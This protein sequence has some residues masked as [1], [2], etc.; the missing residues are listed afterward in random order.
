RLH[1]AG[2]PAARGSVAALGSAGY[3]NQTV[4]FDGG[5]AL[6]N[7]RVDRFALAAN[8]N[9]HLN[10]TRLDVQAGQATVNGAY[11]TAD[12]EIGGIG[13]TSLRYDVGLHV[14]DAPLAPFARQVLPQRR[15]IAGTLSADLRVSG[16][17]Q[18]PAVAGTLALPEGS[19]QGQPFRDARVALGIGP[20]GIWA[21]DGLITVGSTV[22]AFEAGAR[23]RHVS[24]RLEAPHADLSD[25]DDLFDTGDTLAGRGSIA[26]RFTQ[27]GRT[28]ATSADLSMA[29][30]RYLR[31]ALG[32]SQLV[33][34]SRGR[35]V[36]GGGHFGGASGQFAVAGTLVV[37]PSAPFER[38]LQRSA[39]NGTASVRGLDLS[40]WMP[41]LG[42]SL[43][44]SGHVDAD[45]NL[46]GNLQAPDI[47]LK[48]S[49]NDGTFGKIP[50]QRAVVSAT[51][52]LQRLTLTSAEVDLPSLVATGSGTVGLGPHG[53]LALSLHA[54]TDDLGAL[55]TRLT[56]ARLAASGAAEADAKVVGS[57]ELPHIS[58]GFY[59]ENATLQAVAIPRALGQFVL[60]GRNVVLQ[61]GEVAFGKGVLYLAGSL[62]FT[63]SPFAFGPPSAPVEFELSAKDID[64]TDFAPLLPKD[65][66]LQGLLAGRVGVS[67][68]AGA[69]HVAGDLALAHGALTTPFERQP[70]TNIAG[71]LHFSGDSVDLRRLHAEAGGGTLDATGG[72]TL[73]MGARYRVEVVAKHLQLDLPAYGR[74]Q[75]D[76][77]ASLV[78]N[79]PE[80]PQLSANLKL[81]DTVIPF[82]ALFLASGVTEG[83]LA[84]SG[85]LQSA[86]AT[87][88][89]PEVALSLDVA[90]LNNVRV[91]SANV[92][93]GG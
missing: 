17:G 47:S 15:D 14:R 77:T 39:F 68:S 21:R 89:R 67:G 31:F 85:P 16:S 56:G 71:E 84:L 6:A 13:T 86:N 35:T 24:L 33:W 78:R 55:A 25:F 3:E 80:V 60:E 61:S 18:R 7:A 4:R 62:P 87:P 42:Y 72:G 11:G 57:R 75:I 70:L 52:S 82:S 58:G 44:L 63:F 49:L 51:S 90:A 91:R 27:D 34:S 22:A 50:I 45:A 53:G 69:P 29:D 65:S 1:V 43:P 8:G 48:A 26:T 30:L 73:G 2:L 66:S 9:V 79:P 40:T 12:G 28:I 93:I 36:R 38:L 10:G 20:D 54:K 46:G 32:D 76:G 59:A 64:L 19:F 23:P 37:P 5:V 83:P 74:G 81:Q 88:A 41:L 92:D